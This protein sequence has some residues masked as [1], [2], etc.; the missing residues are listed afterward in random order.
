MTQF[1]LRFGKGEVKTKTF[2]RNY[3]NYF[4]YMQIRRECADSQVEGSA[5]L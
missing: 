4:Y 2:L 5:L 1:W 3:H